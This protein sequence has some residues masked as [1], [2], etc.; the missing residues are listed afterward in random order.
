M[1]KTILYGVTRVPFEGIHQ[2]PHK[3]TSH[4]LHR[5]SKVLLLITWQQSS[6]DEKIIEECNNLIAKLK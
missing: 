2:R 4:I 3:I 5:S 1:T 6:L